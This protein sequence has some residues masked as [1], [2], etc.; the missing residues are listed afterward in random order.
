MRL[1]GRV[2]YAGL[3]GHGKEFGFY[4]KFKRK[5][6]KYFEHMLHG[7]F[8]AGVQQWKQGERFEF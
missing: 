7:E 5:L 4:P 8:N 1:V 2:D 6:L 3:V